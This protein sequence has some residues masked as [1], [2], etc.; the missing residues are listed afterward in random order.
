MNIER[1]RRWLVRREDI[2]AEVLAAP[3]EHITQ[4]YL[5]P[6]KLLPVVRVRLLREAHATAPHRGVQTVKMPRAD[7]MAEVEFDIPLGK[8]EELMSLK[9]AGLTKVRHTYP[10]SE[11]LA[12]EVDLF[13][14]EHLGDLC[15]VEVELP[16]Y[17]VPL[18]IPAW[19]GPEITGI[20]ELSNVS[21]AYFP[22]LAAGVVEQ[23]WAAKN[24]D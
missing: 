17:E 16:A 19:F 6:F 20:S 14:G 9:L 21:M 11:A 8:A 13:E 5:S 3:A 7:G 22:I 15:I 1:E 4:G 24:T 18:D 2:P 23:M 10:L 12:Y